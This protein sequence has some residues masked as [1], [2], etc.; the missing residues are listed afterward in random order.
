VQVNSTLEDDHIQIIS[1]LF[2]E[3]TVIPFLGAGVNLFDRMRRPDQTDEMI[4][5]TRGRDLPSGAEL[6]KYLADNWPYPAD[7]SKELLRVSQYLWVRTGARALH[8][9]LRRIFIENYSTTILHRF[10]AKLP[11]ILRS[12]RYPSKPFLI[13]TTN[14][15][16]LLEK[17]FQDAGEPYDVVIYIS[18]G[19][20]HGRFWHWPHRAEIP[21]LIENPNEY[22]GLLLGPREEHGVPWNVILKIHGSID[23]VDKERDSY[24]I[25]EDQ[26]IDYL[27][28]A[29]IS[30]FLPIPLPHILRQGYFLFLGYSLADWNLRVILRRIWKDQKLTGKSWAVQINPRPLEEEFWR[31][32]GVAFVKADLGEY[33][34]RLERYF[35][36]FVKARG[37]P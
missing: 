14:Y 16:D 32:R 33:I 30:N 11:G 15:D 7:E 8:E 19:E 36:A 17:A 18:V 27:A 10:L 37:N 4:R 3:H 35:G 9:D 25:T 2:A 5:W 23:R 6:S 13:V 20:N 1:K 31:D 24:V 22:Q 26:Y 21:I 12:A 34:T 28:Q 29:D